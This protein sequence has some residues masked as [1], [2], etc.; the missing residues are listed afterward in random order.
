M[1]GLITRQEKSVVKREWCGVF[2]K[3]PQAEA[4]SHC[5]NS[6]WG[7]LQLVFHPDTGLRQFPCP[8]GS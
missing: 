4:G 5:K 1:N 7:Q 2:R 6:S 8:A 3:I